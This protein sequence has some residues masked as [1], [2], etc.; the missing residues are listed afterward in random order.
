MKRFW[1]FTFFMLFCSLSFSQEFGINF[2]KTIKIGSDSVNFFEILGSVLAFSQKDTLV[3]V[4]LKDNKELVRLKVRSEKAKD[5]DNI[6][7]TNFHFLD[8]ERI[9]VVNNE[10]YALIYNITKKTVSPLPYNKENVVN[11]KS[12]VFTEKIESIEDIIISPSGNFLI[13]KVHIMNYLLGGFLLL[14]EWYEYNVITYP[15]MERLYTISTK[16]DY[17][18]FDFLMSGKDQY[19]F[20]INPIMASNKK[21]YALIIKD[22]RSGKDLKYFYEKDRIIAY[23]LSKNDKYFAFSLDGK[24]EVVLIDLS[25]LKEI[26]SFPAIGNP[27]ISPLENLIAIEE[28]SEIN[29]FTIND[30]RL[31]LNVRG[32]HPVFSFDEKFLV[33]SL[34]EHFLAPTKEIVIRSLMKEQRRNI[35]LDNEYFLEKMEWTYDNR[36]L[37]LL[38]MGGDGYKILVYEIK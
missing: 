1:V 11:T 10:P 6:S 27:V 3:L 9:F 12:Y 21:S 38:V 24:E 30:K 34:G 31:I 26:A 18:E 33:Y 28:N 22:L 29:I 16:K 20:I 35:S 36:Y 19:L 13:E 14:D 32:S 5:A 2:I 15:K 25:N 17:S 23:N 7:I 4:S 37:I 8:P